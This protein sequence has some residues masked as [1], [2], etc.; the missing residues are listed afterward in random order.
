MKIIQIFIQITLV[1]SVLSCSNT[2]S[3]NENVQSEN[4]ISMDTSMVQIIKDNNNICYR[5]IDQNHVYFLLNNS[6]FIDST[7]K[8]NENIIYKKCME[9]LGGID[10]QLDLLNNEQMPHIDNFDLL[11]EDFHDY[12]DLVSSE[13]LIENEFEIFLRDLDYDQFL[14]SPIDYLLIK[15]QELLLSTIFL[16]SYL[17]TK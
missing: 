6:K 15:K 3:E 12:N 10:F 5:I 9:L 1:V 4:I 13:F 16:Q 2:T 14:K 7:S 8:N 17:I 11:N